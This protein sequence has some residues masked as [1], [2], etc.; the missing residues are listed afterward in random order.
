VTSL[1]IMATSWRLV[2]ILSGRDWCVTAID[3]KHA[4]PVSGTDSLAACVG[5]LQQQVRALALDSHISIGVLAVCLGVLVVIVLAGARLEGKLGRD[6]A[7][8]NVSRDAGKAADL[9]ADA[10]RDQADV[11][12]DAVEPPP[13]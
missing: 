3:A 1:F 6:G 12:K 10:A 7:E 2:S 13:A 11:I 4:T 8:L 5:L 9:V